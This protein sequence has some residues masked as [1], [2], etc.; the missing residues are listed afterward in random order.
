VYVR[1][2]WDEAKAESNRR[3]HRVPFETAVR[4]FDDPQFLLF[5]DR[6]VDGEERWN[7]IGMVGDALVL[8]VAHTARS[9]DGQ[10]IVR[11]ISARKA[12][13]WERRVY[14]DGE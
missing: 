8:A 7:A 10:E 3:K 14:E 12:S 11:I 13:R 9:E 1:F 4:V 5:Q 6:E 2:E